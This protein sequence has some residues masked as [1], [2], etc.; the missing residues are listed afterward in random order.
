MAKRY[1]NNKDINEMLAKL[2]QQGWRLV[3]GNGIIKCYGPDKALSPVTVHQ[4]PSDHRAIKNLRSE[5][6]KRGA[7]L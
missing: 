2:D 5:F 6:R 4:T 1:T 3:E 7:I